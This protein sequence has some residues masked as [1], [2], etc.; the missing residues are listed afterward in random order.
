MIRATQ[1]KNCT[2]DMASNNGLTTTIWA[3]FIYEDGD[4]GDFM[5]VTLNFQSLSAF[6]WYQLPSLGGSYDRV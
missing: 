4:N 5:G 3:T 6:L 1:Q 2:K